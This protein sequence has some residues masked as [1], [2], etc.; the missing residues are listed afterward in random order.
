MSRLLSLAVSFL[1]CPRAWAWDRPLIER[2]MVSTVF[3]MA[4][5]NIACMRS[6][7][8]RFRAPWWD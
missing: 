3:S 4:A 1:D 5:A 8:S 6:S 2:L 7:L